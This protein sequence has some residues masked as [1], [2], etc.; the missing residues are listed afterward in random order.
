[1]AIQVVGVRTSGVKGCSSGG[2]QASHVSSVV[3]DHVLNEGSGWCDLSFEMAGS[4]TKSTCA[5]SVELVFILRFYRGSV[6]IESS[7]TSCLES[8]ARLLGCVFVSGVSVLKPT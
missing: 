8:S 3:I 1:M 5:V 7:E 4:A 2:K 6:W